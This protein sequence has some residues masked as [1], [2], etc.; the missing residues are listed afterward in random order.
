M[1]KLMLSSSPQ[2]APPETSA[3]IVNLS[4]RCSAALYTFC[5]GAD[6]LA[7]K[8][9]PRRAKNYQDKYQIFLVALSILRSF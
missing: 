2:K 5:V 9:M 1:P 4:R 7:P 6:G 3:F 8:Q